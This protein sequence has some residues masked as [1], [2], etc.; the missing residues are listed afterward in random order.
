MCTTQSKT[1]WTDFDKYL[2]NE[3]LIL[4]KLKINITF[5]QLN[6]LCYGNSPCYKA[7]AN[8]FSFII[9]LHKMTFSFFILII[10]KLCL[11]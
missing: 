3:S 1:D 5:D 11:Y 9:I 8:L 4:F 2:T 10:L 6:F 7:I